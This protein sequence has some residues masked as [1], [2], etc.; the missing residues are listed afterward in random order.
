MNYCCTFFYLIISGWGLLGRILQC[1]VNIEVAWTTLSVP[2]IL[3]VCQ[4][5][6]GKKKKA[7]NERLPPLLMM[8]AVTSSRH[9]HR[10]HQ[11]VLWAVVLAY[12]S[13]LFSH[14]HK[15]WLSHWLFWTF[16]SCFN[17]LWHQHDWRHPLVCQ[18]AN[19]SHCSQGCGKLCSSACCPLFYNVSDIWCL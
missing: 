9:M 16:L 8:M 2:W 17:S 19:S 5:C 10:S 13:V 4:Q 18:A 15:V 6:S 1:F 14:S 3:I 7:V 12:A 11:E